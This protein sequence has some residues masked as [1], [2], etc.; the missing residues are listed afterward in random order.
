[1]NRKRPHSSLADR[2]PDE[3]LRDAACDQ[4]GTMIASDVPLKN[5]RKLSDRVRTPLRENPEQFTR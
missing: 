5:L 1:Y 2:T 3:A 4:I